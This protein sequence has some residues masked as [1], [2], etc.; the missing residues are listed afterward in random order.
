MLTD[1][2]ELFYTNNPVGICAL[3]DK[4]LGGGICFCFNLVSS[5]LTFTWVLVGIDGLSQSAQLFAYLCMSPTVNR[6]LPGSQRVHV[7]YQK[8]TFE[9]KV[10]SVNASLPVELS[11]F[12]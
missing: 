3:S 6:L 10:L 12:S 4:K 11:R 7:P 1:P 5:R 8:E 9:K 2:T